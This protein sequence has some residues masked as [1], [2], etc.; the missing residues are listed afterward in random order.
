MDENNII[1]L[2]EET[3]KKQP[4][5]KRFCKKVKTIATKVWDFIEDWWDD[6]ILP[7]LMMLWMFTLG[8]LWGQIAGLLNKENNDANFEA[9]KKKGYNEGYTDCVSD[10]KSSGYQVYGGYGEDSSK[11]IVNK[12]VETVKEEQ[13]V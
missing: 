8:F 3:Q 2:T 7:V 5:Y 10:L 9:G 1:D 4:W 6:V 12:I 13:D 11:M